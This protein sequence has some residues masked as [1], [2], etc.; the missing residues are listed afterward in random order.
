MGIH[1]FKTHLQN[2]MSVIDILEEKGVD[3]NPKK[4]QVHDFEASR[5]AHHQRR[6]FM[7]IE[8]LKKDAVNVRGLEADQMVKLLNNVNLLDNVPL[9][10]AKKRLNKVAAILADAKEP[11]ES[12]T[13][14][15]PKKLPSEIKNEIL[16]DINEIH[17]CFDAGAYRAVVILCGRLLETALHWKYYNETGIDLLEKSPGI[18][19]G[20][21]IAKLRDK[22]INFD[23]G[24]TQQIHLINQ[25]RVFSVHTKKDLFVPSEKQ[26]E[27]IMLY[28]IDILE[29]LV[30]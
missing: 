10:D 27:A 22:N 7:T 8:L 17:Q 13:V 3:L 20:S 6:Y 18:G 15:I 28:T 4:T 25:V 30:K 1:E 23:P 5:L 29:K 9:D 19:L 16:A 2:L 24:I 11:D 26:T 12:K 14:N 21:I